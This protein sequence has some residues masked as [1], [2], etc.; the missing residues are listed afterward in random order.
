MTD[1]CMLYMVTFTINIPQMLAYI[2][3]MDSIVAMMMG[4]LRKC[5][6]SNG[7]NCRTN[8][9]FG[10]SLGWAV[11]T[12]WT[13]LVGGWPTYPSE[14]WWSD[15]QLGWWHSQYDGKVIKFHGSMIDYYIPWNI[16]LKTPWNIPYI[17]ESHKILNGSSH[18]QPVIN[19]H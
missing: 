13:I 2:P 9:D 3:Y 8:G 1:P 17:M 11:D 15:R 16:P 4:H 12:R 18:H 6:L 10:K 19:H 14:K 5:S 7:D